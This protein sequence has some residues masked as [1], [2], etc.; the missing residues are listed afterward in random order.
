M[1]GDAKLGKQLVTLE[2]H[3]NMSGLLFT[4]SCFSLWNHAGFIQGR[5]KTVN[6]FPRLC[7]EY[8]LPF[9]SVVDEK[10]SQLITGSLFD[11]KMNLFFP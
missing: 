5:L 9:D 6:Q 2:R 10:R 8:G 1:L 3:H 7:S 4:L 11:F